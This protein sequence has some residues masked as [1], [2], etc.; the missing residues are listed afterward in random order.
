M[1][2]FYYYLWDTETLGG[3]DLEETADEIMSIFFLFCI[4][5]FSW[6]I[7]GEKS[8]LGYFFLPPEHIYNLYSNF[9]AYT[10]GF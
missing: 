9:K 4:G 2:I 3:G 5:T 1:K 7:G 8:P 10:L 6:K